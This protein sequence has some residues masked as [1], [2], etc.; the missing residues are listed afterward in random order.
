MKSINTFFGLSSNKEEDKILKLIEK[1]H[2]T[3]TRAYSSQTAIEGKILLLSIVYVYYNLK[4]GKNSTAF[5]S[6]LTKFI[7]KLDK[8][9]I[10][11]I[12]DKSSK[13]IK[14]F[15]LERCELYSFFDKYESLIINKGGVPGGTCYCLYI[16]PFC[17][18]QYSQYIMNDNGEY[19]SVNLE[20]NQFLEHVKS[21]RGFLATDDKFV[22]DPSVFLYFAD[23]YFTTHRM[24]VYELLK[25]FE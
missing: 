3:F 15:I 9:I 12:I 14:T 1:H 20:L 16:D 24:F 6:I 10:S 7:S 19:E 11:L 2:K 23:N 18:Y 4:K 17:N 25:I 5:N 22:C 13:N 8:Q 21:D